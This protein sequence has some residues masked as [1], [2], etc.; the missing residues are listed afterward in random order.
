[1]AQHLCCAWIAPQLYSQT[2]RLQCAPRIPLA[3]AHKLLRH[4]SP[5]T[6]GEWMMIQS[7]QAQ[8]SGRTIRTRTGWFAK[9]WR[10]A[11]AL[12]LLAPFAAG[13]ARAADWPTRTVTIVVPYAPGGFTDVLARLA[14]KQLSEKFG[15]PFVI[16]NRLGAAGAIAASY[17]AA[18]A[19]DGYTILFGSAS[20][21][22]VSPLI[23]KVSYDPDAFAPVAIFGTIPFLMGIK[24]SLPAKT[25]PEFVAYA[26]GNPGKL[27]YA[28]AGHGATSHLIS[29]GFATRAGIEMVHVPYKGSA[30][31]TA[32][33]VQGTVEMAW[34]GVSEMAAQMTNEN[35]RVVATS[36]A[37]RLH[38]LPDIPSIAEFYP[39]FSTETWNGFLAPHGTPPEIVDKLAKATIEAAQSP[40]IAKRLTDL[41][42]TPTATTP[43]E[44]A[45]VIK[46]DKVFYPDILKAAGLLPLPSN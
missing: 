11:C 6:T 13:P 26:K 3:L 43:G 37:R 12:A 42:I 24:A 39:G 31:A 9:T 27:N 2:A 34:G 23:Q 10:G 40:D 44:M 28:T 1:V 33:L 36:A 38:H 29:A 16:E 15:Q 21:L 4:Q 45:A 20:Q 8:D 25:V 22:G 7:Q 30:Q 32:A 5:V 41:G 19:P 17:V 14:A 18:A 35:I 46:S